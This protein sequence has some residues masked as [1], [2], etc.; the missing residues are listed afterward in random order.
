MRGGGSRLFRYRENVGRTY[1]DWLFV[2]GG[3]GH[4]LILTF[5]VSSINSLDRGIMP[6]LQSVSTYRKRCHDSL[7]VDLTS[8]CHIL[9][10]LIG[11]GGRGCVLLADRPFPLQRSRAQ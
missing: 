2:M 6:G 5:V 1:G 7:Q 10:E 11:V 4:R 8:P 9:S 3:V